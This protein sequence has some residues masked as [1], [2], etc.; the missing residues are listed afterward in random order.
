MKGELIGP[1]GAIVVDHV[2]VDPGIFALYGFKP[3]AGSLATASPVGDAP[4]GDARGVILNQEAARQLGFAS[5]QAAIGQTLPPGLGS[6]A[7]PAPVIAVVP[8]FTFVSVEEKLQPAAYLPALP[9]AARGNLVSIKLRPGGAAATL[10]G[11]D[12]LWTAT[13]N[14]GPISRFFLADYMQE[15]YR[16]LVRQAQLLTGFSVLGVLLACLGLVGLSIAAAE[17]RIKEIGIRKAMGAT[18]PQVVGLLL[19]QS[20]LPVLLAN[21]VAWPVAFWVMQ[22]WL[23]GFAYHVD[24]QWWVF[25]AA[26]G[27][28]LLLALLTVVAQVIQ[29]ARAKP[30][31][32]L[33]YE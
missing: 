32:A 15:Q 18:T 14:E 31:L 30:V 11:I 4:E 29:T 5:P 8:D 19:W 16:G 10:A 21:L 2:R 13:G 9:N 20:S 22:R 7:P 17:R 33:R 3:L 6:K 28:A 12:R 27:A 23:A 26:S 25:P 24:L 1:A